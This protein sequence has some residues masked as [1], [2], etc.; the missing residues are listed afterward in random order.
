MADTS[1]FSIKIH[2]GGVMK[3]TPEKHYVEGNIDYIDYVNANKL[4][5]DGFKKMAEI[6]GYLKNSITFWH[7]CGRSGNRWRLVSTDNEAHAVRKNIPNDNM[8]EIYFE[9]LDSYFNIEDM[10]SIHSSN[11]ANNNRQQLVQE[12]PL[13]NDFSDS[14][15]ELT[16]GLL[17]DKHEKTAQYIVDEWE[18]LSIESQRKMTAPEEESDCVDSTDTKSLHSDSENEIL[19]FPTFN[20]QTD[21]DNPILA[22]ECVFESKKDFK[23]AV[24]THEI[25]NGKA[26]SLV[27]FRDR[28]SVDLRAH[29]T[30]SQAKRAKMFAIALIDGDIK[31]QYKMMWDYCIEIDRTNPASTIHM[32]F[33]ENEIPNK[34]YKFQRI[35]ICFAA[36]KLAFKVGCRKII[37]VDGC[38]LKGPMYGT[39]LLIAVGIDGNNNIFPIAYAIVEKESKESWV[40]FLNYL[41]ADLDVDETGWTFMSDKQKGFIEAFNEVLPYVS[42]RFCAR[43]LHNNFKRAGFGGFTLKKAFWA[44]AKATTVKEFDACMVRLRELD[45]N[46]AD[47]L[48]D[49][50]PS[51][52]SRSHFS[53]DA[54]CDILLNN[55]CEVFN[56]MILDARDKPIVTLLE[57]LR[58]LLMA[59]MLANREKAHKWSSNDVCPKI[60]DILHKN[61]TAAG[62][63]I[64]RKSNQWNYEIIGATIHDSWAIDLENRI[65]SCRKWSIMG[66]PCKHAIAAIRVKKDII[67]DYVDDCYKVKTYRRIYEHAILPIN[68]PQMWAKSTK[69]PP[70]PPTIV[71][72]KKRGR[73]Q[74]ARRKEADEVGASRTKMKRKQQ[75]LDCSTCNK[76]GHNKKTCKYN[77]VSQETTSVR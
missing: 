41:A 44:A 23:S 36:C 68:G 74:K 6:C 45:S 14:E 39:Q 20:P 2:H 21:G 50:E 62:E 58:Y 71:G 33:T 40:W 29:V 54:K 51:Q 9:H 13:A 76:P 77:V 30:L 22:L 64:P 26:W 37:G 60:K 32:K 11:V 65:C 12:N 17:V 5:L 67:L 70:L 10:T 18:I 42:H 15:V 48:N 75:S 72:N 7:R 16:D 57:K 28:V 34:P 56:S 1:F 53:S 27:D 63:Y 59:R 55:I 73:K 4:D 69:V 25:K 3:C 35:Y 38:W 24:V 8:I 47:W 66:I 31:D 49:K 46:V 43:H 61:Q 52:W 19:N